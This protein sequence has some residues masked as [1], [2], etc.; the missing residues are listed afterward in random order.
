M[1]NSA[2][3]M[4]EDIYKDCS[5]RYKYVCKVINDQ[6][7]RFHEVYLN[8]LRQHHTYRKLK[9]SRE[10][11]LHNGD[12]VLIKDDSHVPRSQWRLG[13]VEKLMIGKDNKVRGAKLTVVS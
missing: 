3:N 9:Y 7:K 13:K 10:N 1:K 4:S 6:W 12:I 8:E 11:S 2:I 5:K